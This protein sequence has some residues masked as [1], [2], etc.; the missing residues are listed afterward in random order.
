MISNTH[1]QTQFARQPGAP[2]YV[3]DPYYGGSDGFEKALDLLDDACEGL[4]DTL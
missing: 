1:L 3:P 2:S 4:L